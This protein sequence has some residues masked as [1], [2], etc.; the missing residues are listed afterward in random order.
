MTT[1]NILLLSTKSSAGE[2]GTRLRAKLHGAGLYL[3]LMMVNR[4]AAQVQRGVLVLLFV[5]GHL[6]PRLKPSEDKALV[7]KLQIQAPRAQNLSGLQM[8]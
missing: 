8:S 5:P 4:R 2:T 7:L 3:G 6:L 1:V